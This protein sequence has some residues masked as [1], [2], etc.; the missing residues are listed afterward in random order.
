MEISASTV[1]V[2]TSPPPN[3]K[4]SVVAAPV[5]QPGQKFWHSANTMNSTP[6]GFHSREKP[7]SAVSPVASV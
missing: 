2:T 6:H 5:A 7:V 4:V 3:A 1:M